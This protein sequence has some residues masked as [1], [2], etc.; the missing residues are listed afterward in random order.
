MNEHVHV[1]VARVYY[2]AGNV[3]FE[4]GDWICKLGLKLCRRGTAHLDTATNIMDAR[5]ARLKP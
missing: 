2:F 3:L 5:I 1:I 4:V